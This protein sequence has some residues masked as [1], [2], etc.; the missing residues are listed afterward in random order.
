[1][2][3]VFRNIGTNDAEYHLAPHTAA[4]RQ[5]LAHP[6]EK[7]HLFLNPPATAF[8]ISM[9]NYCF[10]VLIDSDVFRQQVDRR[11]D[12]ARFFLYTEP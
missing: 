8:V 10:P 11:G 2:Y 12:T 1:M 5:L 9:P 3:L 7:W 4:V 6:S